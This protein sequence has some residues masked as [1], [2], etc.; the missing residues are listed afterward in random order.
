MHVR[1]DGSRA[2]AVRVAARPVRS[3]AHGGRHAF[4]ETAGSARTVG[5]VGM[6]S[7]RR[8]SPVTASQQPAAVVPACPAPRLCVFAASV[9]S[10]FAQLTS[11]LES[12]LPA[13]MPVTVCT[14][15][16]KPACP[17]MAEVSVLDEISKVTSAP[18][19]S[20]T[21]RLL[22]HVTVTVSPAAAVAPSVN[23]KVLAVVASELV[24]A[25]APAVAA[26]AVQEGSTPVL[27]QSAYAFSAVMV[28]VPA[29]G[30]SVAGVNVNT[31]SVAWSP[32]AE[33]LIVALVQAS[34]VEPSQ[35]QLS[36]TLSSRR[37][38]ALVLDPPH[39]CSV[40]TSRSA[41]AA[42]AACAATRALWPPR[43]DAAMHSSTAHVYLPPPRIAAAGP[44]G[45]VS[46][47]KKDE[48]FEW[49]KNAHADVPYFR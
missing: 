13:H 31:T 38:V 48:A 37:T 46:T 12:V 6:G 29:S 26:A 42:C 22:A 30:T 17:V 1:V 39:L 10:P 11:S 47:N 15:M 21:A 8:G 24:I 9:P 3:G 5:G 44:T 23:T 34:A 4:E 33:L 25:I 45:P 16:L 40:R 27:S 32:P 35:T 2:R 36:P 14:A 19:G 49:W 28:T 18:S 43:T 20:F 7:A 41:R